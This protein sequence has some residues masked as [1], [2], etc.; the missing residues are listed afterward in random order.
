M[1][2]AYKLIATYKSVLH[3]PRVATQKWVAV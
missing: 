1:F 3:N 2:G